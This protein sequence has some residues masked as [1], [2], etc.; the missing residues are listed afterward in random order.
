[1]RHPTKSI[2]YTKLANIAKPTR[3]DSPSL[4][5]QRYTYENRMSNNICDNKVNHSFTQC[6]ALQKIYSYENVYVQKLNVT[7]FI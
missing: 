7:D 2:T 4:H 6:L 3:T 1:M 5:Y